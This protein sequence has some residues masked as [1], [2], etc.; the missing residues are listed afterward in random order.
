VLEESVIQRVLGAALRTGGEFA[1]IFVEDKRSSSARLD[2]GKIEELSSGRDRGAGIRVVVGETTGF[3]HTA[4]LSEQGLRAA[5]EAAAAAARS[6]ASGERVVNLTKVTAPRPNEVAIQPDE[7]AKAAKVQLLTRANAAAR[8]EGGAIKQVTARLANSRRRILVANSDGLLADDDQVKTLF[9]VQCVAVGD[10]GMQTGYE[11]IGHT[12][13]WELFDR[14]DVEEHARKVAR[15][16]LTKLNARPA[17]SGTMPVVIGSGGGGV[18][19]HEAC[20]HGLEADLVGKGASVFKGRR[21]EQ[22]ASPLVTL[23]D[24]GT[25]GEEW[26]CFAIDDEGTPAHRNVLIE[27]GVLTDYMYDFLR[28]R[29]EGR[30]RSGNGR[31]ESY[32]HLPMVRMTNTYLLAGADDPADIVAGTERGVFV[33]ALGGGS[34]NTATG[35][36]VFGMTEA[37][38][39][40][41]GEITD[42]LREGNL[43]G[44]GPEVLTMIEAIGNDFAMGP[45]GMCG[46]DGQGVPVGDGVPTLRV[47][48]LTIGG[49]AA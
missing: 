8:G 31:R 4:D 39:I 48:A 24:D 19:F 2:D 37:Y 25:M 42:P 44:N 10:T 47:K 16:A 11:S 28:S 15:Q 26:G 7:I 36:F 17:P 21:G 3:A 46:K 33:K 32:Q 22:V 18:L 34:V 9:A 27:D 1:E 43:I 6:S 14:V 30:P 23:V 38:L 49:T 40:E 13:G 29:K 20:G 35:D 41:N 12:V 5:A 45:P